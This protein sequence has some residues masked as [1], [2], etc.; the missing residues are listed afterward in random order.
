MRVSGKKPKPEGASLIG[1]IYFFESVIPEVTPPYLILAN[2]P[3][4]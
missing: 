2:S 4:S 1:K 3:V